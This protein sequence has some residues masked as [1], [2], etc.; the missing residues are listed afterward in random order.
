MARI[1]DDINQ[2]SDGFAIG[3]DALPSRTGR[4]TC[5]F[6]QTP[7]IQRQDARIGT[8]R[9]CSQEMIL[10]YLRLIIDFHT[11]WL[12]LPSHAYNLIEMIMF[13]ECLAR[14]SNLFPSIFEILCDLCSK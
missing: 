7:R 12:V 8:I 11:V 5:G 13:N 4:P 6:L 14:S 9:C 2:R 10:K 1:D 3:L